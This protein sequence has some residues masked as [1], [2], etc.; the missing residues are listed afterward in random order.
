MS[1]LMAV[2]CVQV[3]CLSCPPLV[4]MAECT[5]LPSSSLSGGTTRPHLRSM[6]IL[7]A[8]KVRAFACNASKTEPSVSKSCKLNDSLSVALPS[9]IHVLQGIVFMCMRFLSHLSLLVSFS[10]FLL[11]VYCSPH[12][13]APLF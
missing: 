5:C 11:F 2:L 4:V 3:S 1:S 10:T 6:W 13:S 12:Q 9:S 8:A 7:I